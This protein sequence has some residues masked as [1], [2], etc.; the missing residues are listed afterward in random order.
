ML[1]L[2]ILS[3]CACFQYKIC[4]TPRGRGGGG[5]DQESHRGGGVSQALS[6][7]S[8]TSNLIRRNL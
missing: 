3:N 8:T 6:H 5:F 1:L 2:W 7:D 4:D